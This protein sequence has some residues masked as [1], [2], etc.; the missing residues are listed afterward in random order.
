MECRKSVRD[1]SGS[2][3]TAYVNA[4][5]A[6]KTAPSRIAAAQTAVTAGGGTPNRY[7]DYVWMHN[8]VGGGAHVGPAFGPWHREFLRQFELDLRAVSGNAH[9]SIPY[10]DWTVD[11]T[12][13]DP[14]WPFTNTFMGGF[15]GSS[16]AFEVT[17]GPFSDPTTWRINIRRAGDSVTRLKRSIGVPAP[18]QLPVR[19]T[20]TPSLTIGAYDASPY[21]SDPSTLTAAQR[22]AQANAAFRKYLEWLLH[23]GVHVWIGGINNAFTDGGDIK[24]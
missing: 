1:L 2:E 7:D 8:V 15:G 10:W 6:L 11:R 22:T 5:L 23:N 9:I 16:P 18:T 17:T 19:G 4:V 20:V 14:G 13:A 24:V 3:R 21:H 12:P